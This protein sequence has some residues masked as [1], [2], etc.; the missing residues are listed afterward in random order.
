MAYKGKLL[1]TLPG[2]KTMRLCVIINDNPVIFQR[3]Y[4][5]FCVSTCSEG[6]TLKT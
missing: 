5:V 4:A 3:Q 2:G 6:E 1:T